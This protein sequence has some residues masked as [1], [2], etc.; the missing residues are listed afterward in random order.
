[1]LILLLPA[2]SGGSDYRRVP[3]DPIQTLKAVMM[4]P[5]RS[6]PKP[7]RPSRFVLA[8]RIICL[9]LWSSPWEQRSGKRPGEQSLSGG[10]IGGWTKGPGNV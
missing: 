2:L 4:P 5:V 9:K 10:R 1:M 8:A 3:R 7:R 6:M